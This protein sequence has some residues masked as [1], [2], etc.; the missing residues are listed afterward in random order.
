MGSAVPGGG[1]RPGRGAVNGNRITF[2]LF[3]VRRGR[4]CWSEPSWICTLGWGRGESVGTILAP[5]ED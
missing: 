5:S 3:V 1:G 4:A 2:E